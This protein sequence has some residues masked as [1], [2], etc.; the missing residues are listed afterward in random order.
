MH[1]PSEII[2]QALTDLSKTD[3]KASRLVNRQWSSCAAIRLFDTLYISPHKTNIDV[4]QSVTQHPI[5]R[6]YVKKLTYDKVGFSTECTYSDYFTRL[7]NQVAPLTHG[8]EGTSDSPDMQINS[9][10]EAATRYYNSRQSLEKVEE[11]C[12]NFDFIKAGYKKWQGHAQYEQKCMKKYEFMR[13]LTMGLQRVSSSTLENITSLNP[14][15]R[16][17]AA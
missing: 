1:F 9:F 6:G 16:N 3:L 10:I 11:E 4:F 7:L 14:N 12:S 13:I 5:L 8:L 17:V 15:I 2:L